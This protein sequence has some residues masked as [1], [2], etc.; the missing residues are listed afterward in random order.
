MGRTGQLARFTVYRFLDEWA[1]ERIQ[2]SNVARIADMTVQRLDEFVSSYREAR[3]RLDSR[4][5]R[6]GELRPLVS[7]RFQH[8]QS[9]SGDALPGAP[10]RDH[11]LRMVL[12]YAHGVGI[13]SE[14]Q[15]LATWFDQFGSERLDRAVHV[16]LGDYAALRGLFEVGAVEWLEEHD[17]YELRPSSSEIL[18]L[19][20]DEDVWEWDE[21]DLGPNQSVGNGHIAFSM[22]AGEVLASLRYSDDGVTDVLLR[23]RFFERTLSLLLG[24]AIPQQPGEVTLLR[25]LLR[26]AVPDLEPPRWSD[27]LTVREHN[28]RFVEWRVELGDGLRA[29]VELSGDEVAAARSL[30]TE[31]LTPGAERLATEV[32][33]SSAL[34][35]LVSGVM[36]FGLSGIGGGVGA[37]LGSAPVPA[38]AG[39]AA[40]G[41]AG[42]VAAHVRSRAD[43]RANKA[44]LAH[45]MTFTATSD[46]V[47][48]R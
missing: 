3:S 34:S 37:L 21:V 29:A 27:L 48:A 2:E 26:V 11:V 22:A 47:D 5:L 20:R 19:L 42:G 36:A 41:L 45:Y 6:P 12:T 43:R 25:S 39:S 46:G 15:T 31:R 30:L 23:H 28:E 38:L 44:L 7:N 4:R 33:R 13:P 35:S 24:H 40:S 9:I 18:E 32:R 10:D 14:L 1:G 8:V 16:A 17:L